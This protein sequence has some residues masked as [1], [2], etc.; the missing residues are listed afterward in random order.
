MVGEKPGMIYVRN[1]YGDAREEKT[2]FRGDRK[3]VGKK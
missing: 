3:Q 1:E 2:R